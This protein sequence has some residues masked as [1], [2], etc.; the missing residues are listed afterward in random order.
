MHLGALMNCGA[1]R[2]VAPVTEHRPL[3]FV[4][5]HVTAQYKFPLQW[6]QIL[7]EISQRFSVRVPCSSHRDQYVLCEDSR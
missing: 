1:Y 7:C 5:L 2:S 6:L 3:H 4:G